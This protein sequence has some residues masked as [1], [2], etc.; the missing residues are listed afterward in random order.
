MV[1]GPM[2]KFVNRWV[3]SH[4]PRRSTEAQ[5]SNNPKHQATLHK[6]SRNI[7]HHFEKDERIYHSEKPKDSIRLYSQNIRGVCMGNIAK[8]ESVKNS[9]NSL[10]VDII[11]IQEVNDTLPEHHRVKIQQALTIADKR[12]CLDKST[13][14][15]YKHRT[16]HQPGDG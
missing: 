10:E 9:I 13:L 4:T 5:E 8:L 12:A 16:T 7:T 3:N 11:C 2:D 6:Y 1:L 15:P 14:Q